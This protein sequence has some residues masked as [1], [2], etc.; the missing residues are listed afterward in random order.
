MVESFSVKGS[1][2]GSSRSQAFGGPK[3]K[4]LV[5]CQGLGGNPSSLAAKKMAPNKK[6]P[7]SGIYSAQT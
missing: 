3:P 7:N 2:C 5:N 6:P 4:K 1:R